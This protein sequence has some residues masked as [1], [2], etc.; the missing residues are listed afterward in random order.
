[1]IQITQ[2]KLPYTHSEADLKNKIKKTLRLSN[3]QT[4]TY[5][6]TKKSSGTKYHLVLCYHIKVTQVK[7]NRQN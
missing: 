6:V 5:K 1:M 4:F 7:L 3:G 2:L